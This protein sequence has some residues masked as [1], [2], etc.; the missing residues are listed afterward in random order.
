MVIYLSWNIQLDAKKNI[1]SYS[2]NILNN[3]SILGYTK[4]EV[5]FKYK[6]DFKEY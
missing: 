5:C 2:N 6:L 4:E 3:N 1:I